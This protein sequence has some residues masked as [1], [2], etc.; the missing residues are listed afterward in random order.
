MFNRTIRATTIF[1]VLVVGP[2]CQ[3]P[4]A[5][6]PETAPGASFTVSRT[7]RDSASD[8]D[9]ASIALEPL[10]VPPPDRWPAPAT[11]AHGGCRQSGGK[12]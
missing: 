4:V 2:A 3:G 7:E 12:D 5:S 8:A 6:E 9:S 1:L 11:L 10:F